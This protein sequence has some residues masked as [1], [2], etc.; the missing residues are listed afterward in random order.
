MCLCV[1]NMV[2]VCVGTGVC[3]CECNMVNVCVCI[4][5]LVCVGTV[6]VYVCN[7]VCLCNMV[8][9]CVGTV[10]PLHAADGLQ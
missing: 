1:C 7:M 8:N 2:N 10:L 5:L 9:V 4:T 3:M 6:C